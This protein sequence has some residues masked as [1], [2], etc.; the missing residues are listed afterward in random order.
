MTLVSVNTG[1]PRDVRVNGDAVRTSIWKSPREGRVR[2]AG[3]NLEGDEQSDLTVHGGQYKAVYAYPSEH[4]S[5]WRRELPG[6]DLSWGVF[7]ENLTTE[8]LLETDVCIGDR[9]RIGTAEFQVT[10]PRQPCFKLGIRFGR[11]DM[12]KR[13][14]A[15]G[16]SGFYLSIVAEGDVGRGDA[17]HVTH[18]AAD[19]I[20]VAEIF[21]LKMGGHASSDALRRAASIEALAPSWRDHFRGLLR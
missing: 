21:A 9:L 7:G 1:R 17:I 8:G 6:V 4:Y 19:S 15:S 12:L 20:S 14:V 18:R 11:E 10:Q 16:R 13:F 2:V 3:V 5:Y